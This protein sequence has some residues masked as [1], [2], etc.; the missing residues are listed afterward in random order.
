[1]TSASHGIRDLDNNRAMP[2][3]TPDNFVVQNLERWTTL[4]QI[5]RDED[6]VVLPGKTGPLMPLS[7]YVP[8][9][10]PEVAVATLQRAWL[11]TSD[12]V[13][14]TE[15]GESLEKV[16]VTTEAFLVSSSK[17]ALVLGRPLR[18]C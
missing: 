11:V 9:S 7:A 5:L 15:H 13:V 6:V 3:Q 16:A 10:R 1:V 4:E 2:A 14:E 18:R 8:T 17:K 12:Q